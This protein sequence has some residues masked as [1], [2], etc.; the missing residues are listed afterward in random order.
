MV[1]FP[2]IDLA[3]LGCGDTDA[4]LDGL[5]AEC[6]CSGVVADVQGPAGTTG[7]DQHDVPSMILGDLPQDTGHGR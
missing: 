4:H 5:G 7:E 2:A 6:G 1:D 3:L